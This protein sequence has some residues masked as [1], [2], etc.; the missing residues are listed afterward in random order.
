MADSVHTTGV[1]KIDRRDV[2]RMAWETYRKQCADSA[3]PYS[4]KLFAAHLRSA[5]SVCRG[6]AFRVQ[7]EAEEAE[8]INSADPAV[9]RAA[10]IR[11]ELRSME[12][13][14]RIDWPRHRALSAE[15]FHL[16]A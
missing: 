1:P 16:A 15:L 13:G 12:Y 8:R 6:L 3:F 9:R 2:M 14:D 7:V 10:E 11:S 5:W 4:R